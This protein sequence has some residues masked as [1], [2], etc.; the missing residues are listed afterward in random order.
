MKKRKLIVLDIDDTLTSS[1]EKH[2]NSLLYAMDK[3]GIKNVD[4]DWRNYANATDS[5]IFKVNYEKTFNKEFSLE[6]IPEFEKIMT[7]YFIGFPDSK[8]VLGA[9]KIVDFFIEKT[10]YGVCFATG[11]ILKPAYLKLEQAGVEFDKEVLEASNTIFTREKIVQSAI[12]KAKIF[13]KVEDF[14]HVIS[15]GDGLWDVTTAANL[16]LHFVGVNTKNVEDFKKKNVKYHINN[17]EDF[18]LDEVE[19]VFNIS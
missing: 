8:E 15:F 10:D 4:T 17:W 13:Y 19:K 3:F 5:Y 6:I 16:D 11:S 18:S 12:N 2:T 1:E 7:D 14:E 9:K